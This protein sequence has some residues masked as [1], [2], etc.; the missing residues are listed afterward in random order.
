MLEGQ[1][2]KSTKSKEFTSVINKIKPSPFLARYFKETEAQAEVKKE[3]ENIYK[4]LV[5]KYPQAFRTSGAWALENP[6]EAQE[7]IDTINNFLE[8]K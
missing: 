7:I 8:N 2:E 1:K 6:E 4:D 3:F 5:K